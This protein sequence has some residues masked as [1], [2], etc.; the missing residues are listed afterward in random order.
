MG[1]T[2]REVSEKR[3]F[4]SNGFS[5]LHSFIDREMSGMG[6]IEERTH[7][8]HTEIAKMLTRRIRDG[9]YIGEVSDSPDTVSEN[10]PHSVTQLEWQYANATH[11]YRF[12]RQYRV[13]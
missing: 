12:S 7:D 1:M 10:L 3:A 6:A 9:L 13:D 4:G 5:K 8:E 11:G 2:M